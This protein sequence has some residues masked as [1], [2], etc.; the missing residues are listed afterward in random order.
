MTILLN[1]LCKLYELSELGNIGTALLVT[2]DVEALNTNIPHQEGLEA[3]N[4]FLQQRAEEEL[5]PRDFIVTLTEWTLKN[6]VFVFQDKI[7]KQLQGTAMGA[8][9]CPK[10]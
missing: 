6:N 9:L 10:L 5:P 2:M 4:Y 1:L 8:A 7:Y 3:L